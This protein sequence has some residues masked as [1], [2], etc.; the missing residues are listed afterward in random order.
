MLLDTTNK[1][2]QIENFTN[3]TIVLRDST[4]AFSKYNMTITVEPLN[5][6]L[7]SNQTN[8]YYNWSES[9]SVPIHV[10]SQKVVDAVS[11]M[12]DTAI[13]N[14]SYNKNASLLSI[15][16]LPIQNWKPVWVKLMSNDSCSRITY[17]NQY[18]IYFYDGYPPAITNTFGPISVNRGEGRLFPLPSD[19]FTDPQ[20][21]TLALSVSNCVDK[22]HYFTNIELSKRNK[23]EYYIYAQSNDTFTSWIFE[24][25]ATNS[26]NISNQYR[27]QLNIIQWASKDWV[28]WNGSIQSD[29]T[30][31]IQGYELSGSGA[32]LVTSS[33]FTLSQ[34]IIF[35]ILGIIVWILIIIQLLFCIKLKF[36]SFYSLFY[37]QTILVMMF[38]AENV[39]DGFTVFAY[40]LQW[41]K[42]DLS[43]MLFGIHKQLGCEQSSNK[44][45]KLGFYCKSTIHNYMLLIILVIV[46][47]V[48]IVGIKKYL[49]HTIIIQKL[50]SFLLFIWDGNILSLI[51]IPINI[52]PFIIANAIMDVIN[53]KDQFALSFILIGAWS[54]ILF[55]SWF[56]WQNIF[57]ENFICQIDKVNTTCYFCLNLARII[58]LSLMLVLVSNIFMYCTF[59]FILMTLQFSMTLTQFKDNR[60]LLDNQLKERL[61]HRVVGPHMLFLMFVI[62]SANIYE[63]ESFQ[64]IWAFMVTEFYIFILVLNLMIN[65]IKIKK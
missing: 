57:N 61:V 36:L 32:C 58:V 48:A 41:T 25:Y 63:T 39:S 44:M 11:W 51:L 31:W 62:W 29:C 54:I 49:S 43:F 4:N 59:T 53:I 55:I 28:K 15:K 21:L 1:L 26:F 42:F 14:L 8:F 64:K 56:Y 52:S 27:T 35:R 60:V 17:S 47:V 37:M 34:F 50:E 30:N 18:W 5:V 40:T 38:S 20:N 2:L 9:I 46:M 24:I 7:F 45:M 16:F 23:D 33:L 19:L 13:K 65:L 22:S 6:P 10:Q 3:I 12:N